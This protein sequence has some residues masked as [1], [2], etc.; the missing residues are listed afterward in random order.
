M[1][2]RGKLAKAL[3]TALLMSR[4]LLICVF[5][6]AAVHAGGPLP[7]NRE[8]ILR[9]LQVKPAPAPSVAPKMEDVSEVVGVRFVNV[10]LDS[11]LAPGSLDEISIGFEPGLAKKMRP[12]IRLGG[13]DFLL[14]DWGG[15]AALTLAHPDFGTAVVPVYLK[16]RAIVIWWDGT[17]TGTRVFSKEEFEKK[18]GEKIESPARIPSSLLPPPNDRC[19]NAQPVYII[20]GDLTIVS[21]TNVNAEPSDVPPAP[22]FC[23]SAAEYFSFIDGVYHNTQGVWF[24]FEGT[25]D[26]ITIDT[27]G[28]SSLYDPT[29]SVFCG[30]CTN[31]TC[32]SP[33]AHNDDARDLCPGSHSILD[34]L[35][36]VKTLPGQQ[37]YVRVG[38][39]VFSTPAG[40][41]DLNIRDDGIPVDLECDADMCS[42]PHEY[43]CGDPCL[44]DRGC[45]FSY[46]RGAARPP[47]C[48]DTACCQAVCA[49]DPSCCRV[50]WGLNCVMTAMGICTR[51]CDEPDEYGD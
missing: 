28:S 16:D 11:R 31:L 14:Q 30:D 43:Y 36:T 12:V 33:M 48:D 41:F 24:T 10:Q 27:C 23:E 39:Y 34:A 22:A 44:G 47:F 1:T 20:R 5:A 25:G 4:T 8:E 26:T 6:A 49:L 3:P 19:E 38:G 17:P 46:V 15:K 29:L 21:G 35:V 42:A 37:Y 32:G 51:A 40:S 7:A 45:C 9:T 50:T 13:G 2:K 18:R